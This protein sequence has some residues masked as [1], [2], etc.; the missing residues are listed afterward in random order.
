MNWEWEGTV[1]ENCV[2]FHKV[3]EEWGGLSNMNNDF[4]LVVAGVRVRSSEALYQAMRF[5]HRPDWQKEVLDAPHAMRAKMESKKEGRRKTGSRPDW[6]QVQEE[7]MRWVLRV[8]LA[9]NLRAFGRLLKETRD[10]LIVERSRRDRYWGA[11]LEVDGVL[12]GE[13]RLGR[14]LMELREE[15]AARGEAALARVEPPAIGDFLLLGEPVGVVEGRKTD[16]SYQHRR[17][18]G[19]ILTVPPRVEVRA[20]ATTTF[21]VAATREIVEGGVVVE[22]EAP[23]ELTLLSL[24]I[25]ADQSTGQATVSAGKA[26]KEEDY[27][28]RAMASCDTVTATHQN[29]FIRVIRS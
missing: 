10:R 14:L 20:G 15:L 12:R 3:N 11:V 22:F 7:V 17:L 4:P 16:Q 28:V 25:N 9:C 13:N 19:L 5:P 1:H 24:T 6:E 18:K 23:K 26:A 27:P 29:M 21:P 8:K 2:E